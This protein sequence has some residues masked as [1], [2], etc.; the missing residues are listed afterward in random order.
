MLPQGHLMAWQVE[1][2]THISIQQNNSALLVMGKQT[3]F[4]FY[5]GALSMNTCNPGENVLCVYLCRF[6]FRLLRIDLRY[7]LYIYIFIY[8]HL[9]I[10]IY[11]C[12]CIYIY[13]CSS[14]TPKNTKPKKMILGVY[15]PALGDRLDPSF[16]PT[17]HWG[18]CDTM[19]GHKRPK[20]KATKSREVYEVTGI[21]LRW[22]NIAMENGPFEDVSVENGDI[23]L[24]C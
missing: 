10:Y 21:T 22:T 5:G 18:I 6:V 17:G 3:F 4:F 19:W 12:M 11:M 8:T 23:P 14:R 9:F 16:W 1:H 13:T 15:H 2:L 20:S 7:T 24:L